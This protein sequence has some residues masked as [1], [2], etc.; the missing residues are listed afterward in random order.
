MWSCVGNKAQ[1]RWLWHAIDH[2]T[3]GAFI[4]M[5]PESMNGT[6]PPLLIP[7]VR[8]TR[9]RSNVNTHAAHTDQVLSMQNYL[10]LQIGVHA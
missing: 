4:L 6:C 8:A 2:L 1:Q 10:F 5:G 9:S 3:G 7:W